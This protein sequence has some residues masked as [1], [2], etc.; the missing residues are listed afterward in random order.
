MAEQCGASP[1]TLACAR[2]DVDE[3]RLDLTHGAVGT[4]QQA[5]FGGGDKDTVQL[6]AD[7]GQLPTRG[8]QPDHLTHPTAV[9]GDAVVAAAENLAAPMLPKSPTTPQQTLDAADAENYYAAAAAAQSAAAAAATL[10]GGARRPDLP[11]VN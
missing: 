9:A 4:P 3:Y 2:T 8:L 7:C 1:P 10:A 5:S 11:T 6:Y